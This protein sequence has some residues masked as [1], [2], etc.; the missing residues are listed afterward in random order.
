MYKRQT[1]AEG[2]ILAQH[3]SSPDALPPFD[4]SA[5]DGV[6]LATAGNGARAG[7]DYVI[8]GTVA[9]GEVP[10]TADGA[11]WEIMTG[12]ALP[13]GAD[14]VVPSE[15]LEILAQHAERPSLIRLRADVR[16]GQHIRRR[17]EDV[18]VHDLSLIHI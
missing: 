5:M 11:A 16:A 9:A 13:A 4:N 17:G 6:A 3:V 18:A 15:Q 2:R 1:E 8:A 7:S 12:A 10:A 14:A